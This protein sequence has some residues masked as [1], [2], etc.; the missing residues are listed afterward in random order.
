[1]QTYLDAYT[2]R[3]RK[4][5]ET[6]VGLKCSLDFP[7]VLREMCTRNPY[8]SVIQGTLPASQVELGFLRDI[9]PFV[10]P[11]RFKTPPIAIMIGADTVSIFRNSDVNKSV[12]EAAARDISFACAAYVDLPHGA[13]PVGENM[14]IRAILAVPDVSG[15]RFT[16]AIGLGGSNKTRHFSWQ[17]GSNVV[18]GGAEVNACA[19][20]MATHIHLGITVTEC[21][22]PIEHLLGRRPR[23]IRRVL[24]EIETVALLSIAQFRSILDAGEGAAFVDLPYIGLGDQRRR[25]G[26]RKKT[27]RENSFFRI[28]RMP[29]LRGVT[30]QAASRPQPLSA[31]DDDAVARRR[32][33]TVR[34]FFRMQPYGPRRSLRHLIWVRTHTRWIRDDGRVEML[35]LPRPAPAIA[36][37][38]DDLLGLAATDWD[39]GNVAADYRKEEQV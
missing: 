11:E 30:V 22:E 39:I 13:F 15:L 14:Q 37:E 38:L 5:L 4:E 20:E 6:A 33:V 3:L 29:H 31:S 12:G 16:A 28:R 9:H 10:E 23:R 32:F 26:N 18:T 36:P 25:T 34:G 27:E 21:D 24:R 8:L 17:A 2:S 1:M 7:E 19:T 35:A